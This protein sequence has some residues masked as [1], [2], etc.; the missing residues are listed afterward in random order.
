M[1]TVM[2]QAFLRWWLGCEHRSR[3]KTWDVWSTGY[4]NPYDFAF[5]ADGEMFVYDADMEWDVGRT[6]V[7]SD[8]G[9]PRDEWQ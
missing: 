8:A 5:N 2:P 6:L 1:P 7:S 4:R 9:E 3:W